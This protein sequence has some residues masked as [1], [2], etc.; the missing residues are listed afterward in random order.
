MAAPFAPS[1][2][3]RP[4]CAIVQV[5]KNTMAAAAAECR[6]AEKNV[7]KCRE[8]VDEAIE[9]IEMTKV[10]AKSAVAAAKRAAAGA[11]EVQIMSHEARVV[12]EEAEEKKQ[13]TQLPRV[14]VRGHKGA[15]QDQGPSPARPSPLVCCAPRKRSRQSS[16]KSL[17]R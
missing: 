9:K 1:P 14:G 12:A 11:T 3:H 8:K 13:V 15:E 7:V 16:S 17:T 5:D 2:L 10:M 6:E 4:P